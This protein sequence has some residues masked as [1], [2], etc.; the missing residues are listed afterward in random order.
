MLGRTNLHVIVTQ[1]GVN[2]VTRSK[3]NNLNIS[4]HL[5]L[6]YKLLHYLEFTHT[7][8]KMYSL[9]CA[10]ETR[11]SLLPRSGVMFG[12]AISLSSAPMTSFPQTSF[13]YIPLTPKAPATL[14]RPILME[15]LISSSAKWLQAVAT[16]TRKRSRTHL[17]WQI[18]L[19]PC[20]ASILTIKYMTSMATCK[21][22]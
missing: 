17:L 2:C 5:L 20:S 4:L 11:E 16:P 21:W 10:T 1:Y 22:Q 9:V 8:F 19:A 6:L 7:N 14:R 18:S 3:C 15:R 12:W 13:C